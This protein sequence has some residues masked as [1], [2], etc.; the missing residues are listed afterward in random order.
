MESNFESKLEEINKL[1][2]CWINRTLTIYG[3]ATIVKSLVLPKLTHLALV[4]PNLELTKIKRLEN[5]I[6]LSFGEINQIKLKGKMQ[7]V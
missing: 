5:L 6:F 1:L 4:L 3:K 7:I 2:N